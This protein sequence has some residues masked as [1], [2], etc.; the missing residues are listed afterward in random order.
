MLKN[1]FDTNLD[2]K[3]DYLIL[4]QMSKNIVVLFRIGVFSQSNRS[5][6]KQT[7]C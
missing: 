6:N 3:L 1:E 5:S 4:L 2:I 7:N